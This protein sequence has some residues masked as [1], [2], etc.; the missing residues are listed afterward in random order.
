M[1]H[2]II[3]S[4]PCVWFQ[5][6]QRDHRPSFRPSMLDFEKAAG[7][8][9]PVNSRIF[10]RD[11]TKKTQLTVLTDRSQ[12]G[13]SLANGSLELM[14]HRRLIGDDGRGLEEALN[15]LGY[16]GR[17][18]VVRGKNYLVL[19]SIEEAPSIHRPLA[20]ELI[21]QPVF[22]FQNEKLPRNAPS[23]LT[24]A[25][26][27]LSPNVHLLTLQT[28]DFAKSPGT[29]LLRLEHFFE[30]DEDEELSRPATVNLTR[31]FQPSFKVDSLQETT[32]TGTLLKSEENR[33]KWKVKANSDEGEGISS[34]ST[35]HFKP[36]Q[37]LVDEDPFSIT[38]NPMEIRTFLLNIK[39]N[40][41]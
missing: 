16:E 33:M 24:P 36:L 34:F 1:Y 37:R 30:K 11:E 25:L 5:E 28:P 27:E 35:S 39:Q 9:Y 21:M 19:S 32:L 14:L 23:N 40:T 4:R 38:L 22:L 7:N 26:T 2:F 8:Y 20:Q 10:I 29:L 13:S 17:G 3:L 6:R 15:E 41:N 12:G 31:L 18:L